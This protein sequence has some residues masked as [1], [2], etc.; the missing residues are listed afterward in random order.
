MMQII[1]VLHKINHKGV[2]HTILHKPF[3]PL[4]WLSNLKADLN[5][6]LWKKSSNIQKLLWVMWAHFPKT[7]WFH[8]QEIEKDEL[9]NVSSIIDR[10]HEKVSFYYQTTL[11]IDT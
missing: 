4:S 5:F 10:Q 6:V 1:L 3:Y 7:I 8:E 11:L 9:R 2:S